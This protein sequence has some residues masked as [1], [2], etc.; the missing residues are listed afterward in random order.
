MNE[1]VITTAEQW[2][3]ARESAERDCYFAAAW[4]ELPL[5]TWHRIL[6]LRPDMAHWV[7]HAKNAP[8][9]ILTVLAGHSDWQVRSMVATRRKAGPLLE[10]L[11][12]DPDSSVRKRVAYNAKTP[13]RILE[14]LYSDP[15]PLISQPA[16]RKLKDRRS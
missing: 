15:D 12:R 9:E 5:E 7:A 4:C 8:I 3:V 1:V 13:D 6:D 16:Q 14:E 10:L 2:I 11:S